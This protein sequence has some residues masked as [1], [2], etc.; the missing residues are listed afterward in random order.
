MTKQ[1]DYSDCKN[2]VKLDLLADFK[3]M[4]E[5]NSK[6]FYSCGCVQSAHLCMI[7]LVKG[8][9]PKEA[10]EHCMKDAGHSG[11]SAAITATIIAKY[12]LRGDEFKKWCI[13][14]DVVMVDW[15]D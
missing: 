7:Q 3:K 2:Y 4:C 8:D 6:D 14:D 13:K 1:K 15:K 9:T 10:W 5:I 11:M 12:S